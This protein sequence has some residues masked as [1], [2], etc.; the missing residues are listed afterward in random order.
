MHITATRM[1]A[2]EC[3]V[4]KYKISATIRRGSLEGAPNDSGVLENGDAQI[5]PSKFRTVRAAHII[6]R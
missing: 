4:F 3:S 6:I 2:N 1:K 5:F